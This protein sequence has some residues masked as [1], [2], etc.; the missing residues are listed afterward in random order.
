MTLM[1]INKTENPKPDFNKMSYQ[2]I[3]IY[4]ETEA[5]RRLG[6]EAK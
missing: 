1:K 5:K 4:V 2:E 3:L 6:Q